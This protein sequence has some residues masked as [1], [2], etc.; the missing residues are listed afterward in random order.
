M[1]SLKKN[2][3]LLNMV[4]HLSCVTFL[5]T[6]ETCSYTHFTN[7]KLSHVESNIMSFLS[8]EI[9]YFILV[10]FWLKVPPPT[11]SSFPLLPVTMCF[12]LANGEECVP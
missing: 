11:P 12:K 2:Y 10:W 8:K 1:P 9:G 3:Y 6:A 5:L 4:F 7:K